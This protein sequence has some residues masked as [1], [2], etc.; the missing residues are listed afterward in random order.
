MIEILTPS[1]GGLLLIREHRDWP[2]PFLI[3]IKQEGAHWRVPFPA[4]AL[5]VSVPQVRRERPCTVVV[6]P[7]DIL[8]RLA[9][10]SA[11]YE[12][13][14]EDGL[15]AV[16]SGTG[17][18]GTKSVSRY[19]NGLRFEDGTHIQSRHESLSG[20]MIQ[21]IYDQDADRVSMLVR[22]FR[23][24]I[25][26]AAHLALVP[27]AFDGL[28]VVHLVRDG[29]RVVQSGLNRGWYQNDNLWNRMKPKF[30]GDAF[31]QSCR[32][33][34]QMNQTL[35]GIAGLRVRLED[36]ISNVVERQKL[37]EFLEIE[38]TNVP[39]P[40]K[41]LGAVSS[42]VESWSPSERAT[43]GRICG[44]LMDKYYPGWSQE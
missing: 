11:S 7:G 28:K 9:G 10:R 23:H 18:C 34:V 25:E 31:T 12:V 4:D 17:R 42:N 13:S 15:R 8:R 19:L 22:S 16:I 6:K 5:E 40:H 27:Q 14:P 44:D 33:W 20:H 41:N 35:E 2:R 26:V 37:L 32:F 29:R 24:H 36:L 21:H 1:T 3:K 39:F 38:D 43:F 30:D